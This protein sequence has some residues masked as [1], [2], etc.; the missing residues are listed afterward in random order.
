[1]RN[2]NSSSDL[3]VWTRVVCAAVLIW[4]VLPFVKFP[5]LLNWIESR[6]RH[7]ALPEAELQQW[8][9]TVVKVA[10]LRYFVI[11]SNCLKK[12]LLMYYFLLRFG[13]KNATIHIG[14]CKTNVKLEG[15]AWLTVDGNVFL[16]TEEFVE[17]YKVIYA[18][19]VN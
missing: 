1:M 7:A 10:Q 14:V 3:A 12:S 15:H 8:V 11:R 13:V 18:S 9:D 2:R 5:R 17:K 6:Q 4:V 19:G 16:D